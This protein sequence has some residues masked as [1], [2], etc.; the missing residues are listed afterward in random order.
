MQKQNVSINF[1]PSV[2]C[3]FFY[4][5]NRATWYLYVAAD[6][7]E[8]WDQSNS[9]PEEAKWILQVRGIW[10]YYNNDSKLPT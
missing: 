9:I 8:R 4:V 1:L 2:M 7:L 6:R 5:V 10:E 3:Y